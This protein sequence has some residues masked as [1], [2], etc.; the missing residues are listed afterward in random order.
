MAARQH[1][2]R[3]RVVWTGN[4]GVGT[5]AY[6]DYGRDHEIASPG[7]ASIAGSSDPAFLGNSARWNPE[8]LLVASISACHQLW[9]LHLCSTHGV[10][11][12][13]YDDEAEGMMVEEADGAGRFIGVT[14]RPRI[15]LAPGADAAK[16]ASLH[17]QAHEKCFIANSVNFPVAIEPSFET[18]AG[19]AA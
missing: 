11:V 18:A 4:R 8:E 14:L 6:R 12:E 10:I 3:A 7:K 2:Y 15:G 17:R 19:G 13:R 9:Y 1:R 16:A 5:R